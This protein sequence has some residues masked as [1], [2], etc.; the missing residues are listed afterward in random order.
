MNTFKTILIAIFAVSV[1]IANAQGIRNTKE[2]LDNRKAI[3]TGTSQLEKDYLQLKSFKFKV[4]AFENAFINHN[5][6]K[7]KVLKA[8]I[9]SDMKREIAQSERKIKQDQQ[10]IKQ[11]K[12]ELVASKREVQYSRRNASTRALVDDIRD[13]NDD[14][15]DLKDDIRDLQDQI[16]RT[17]RQKEI[18]KKIKSYNFLAKQKASGKQKLMVNTKLLREFTATMEADI[19]ATKKE[20]KEDKREIYEDRRERREDRRS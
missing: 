3:K 18:Y 2:A 1:S 16:A 14:K 17:N 13:K 6:K 8:D 7:V 4:N 12:R 20:I 15:R 19:A 10:E 9:L 5:R 11:S